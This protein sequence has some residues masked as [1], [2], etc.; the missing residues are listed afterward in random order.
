MNGIAETPKEIMPEP[1]P[2]H[3]YAQTDEYGRIT[4]VN[5]SAFVGDNWGVEIDQ[6]Y[7]DQH[8][9]AQGNYFEGGLYTEDGIPRYKLEDGQ[10]V[11]RTEEEIEADRAEI[12][13]KTPEPTQ[14]DRV[15][16]QTTYTAMMTDTLLPEEV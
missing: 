7:G 15:E 4:A 13:Q 8:H 11:E 12:S 1:A 5:S 9:H 14:L 2:Y 3:V 16:A 10:A 6:G